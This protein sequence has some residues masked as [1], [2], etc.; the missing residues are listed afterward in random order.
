MNDV[1]LEMTG[2]GKRYGIRNTKKALEGFSVKLQEGMCLAL[3]GRN[4]AGKSTA[5]K[6]MA[7]VLK[8]TEG[9]VI[10]HGRVSYVPENMGI[11]PTLNVEE[12]VKFFYD[13]SEGHSDYER[14]LSRLNIMG[15]SKVLASHLSKGMRRKLSVAV[16]MAQNPDVVIFDEP[17][18]GVD[19][20]SSEEIVAMIRDMKMHN[21]AVVLSSHNIS[22][23]DSIA[24]EVIVIDSGRIV[25]RIELPLE[26]MKVVR[27]AAEYEKVDDVLKSLGLKYDM[28]RFPYVRIGADSTQEDLNSILV[29]SGLRVLEFRDLTIAEIYGDVLNDVSGT[30]Q[31]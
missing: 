25:R 22:Y 18:D 20:T 17:F 15:S 23:I 21:K 11:Y 1:L 12:N 29:H 27:F 26:W 9:R 6:I 31:S 13:I 5:L 8:P 19:Q 16:A 30:V 24:D 28:S 14:I 3:I 7:N 10:V 2:V 4:G